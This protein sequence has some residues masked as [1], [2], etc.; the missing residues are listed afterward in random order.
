MSICP[1]AGDSYNRERTHDC[2]EADFEAPNEKPPA[3]SVVETAS[4][5]ATLRMW[6]TLSIACPSPIRRLS[7]GAAKLRLATTID[8]SIGHGQPTFVEAVFTLFERL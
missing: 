4:V 2:D 8:K 6:F 5:I 3:T 1:V 7:P